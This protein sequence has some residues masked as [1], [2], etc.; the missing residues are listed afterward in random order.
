MTTKR[1][2]PASLVRDAYRRGDQSLATFGD[3][4]VLTAD[5]VRY[6]IFDIPRGR[7]AWREFLNQ[8]WFIISVAVLPMILV[9]IPF[10]V[11][12]SVQV[13]A[14]AEQVGAASFVGA[15]SGLGVL[16]QGAPMVTALMLAGAVGSAIAADLGARTIRE[17]IDAMEVM[18]L[19]P[20]QRIVAPRLLAT[21]VTGP[22]L[23][24]IVA[25]SGVVTGYVFNVV[26]Q[27]GTPG[28]FVASF[29]D[30]AQPADLLLALA[31]ATVFGFIVGVVACSRGLSASGG[32]RGVADA[33]NA[34]VVLSV[35]LLFATNVVMT[36][37]YAMVVPR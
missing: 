16:K 32:P 21:V 4:L 37:L 11:I 1:T 6:M 7:F 17:E 36:Q 18:G 27:S 20:A 31:K 12:I 28:S 5:A 2:L 23:C 26:A 14:L 35:V 34:T 15:A 19:P 24:G 3:V 10:G 30:F 13:G 29:S 25:F 22:L 8:C 33:V 9:A